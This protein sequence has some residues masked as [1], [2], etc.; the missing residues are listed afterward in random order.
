VSELPQIDTVRDDV[1]PLPWYA[2]VARWVASWSLT[3]ITREAF[4]RVKDGTSRS[5]KD[6]LA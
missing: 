1:D 6:L 5:N 3:A 4:F 2:N